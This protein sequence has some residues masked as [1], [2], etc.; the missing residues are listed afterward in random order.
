M[1]ATPHVRH[2]LRV[3]LVPS[4]DI[5]GYLLV[6]HKND[7][8]PCIVFMS[9]SLAAVVEDNFIANGF[10]H[11]AVRVLIGPLEGSVSIRQALMQRFSQPIR[12]D[13]LHLVDSPLRVFLPPSVN[14]NKINREACGIHKQKQPRRRQ[15]NVHP[16]ADKYTKRRKAAKH[17]KRRERHR[18]C[19]RRPSRSTKTAQPGTTC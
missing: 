6:A 7:T 4:P 5:F 16:S 18:A 17:T 15:R 3:V 19:A 2:R 11:T 10:L 9:L 13:T 1:K 8:L 12:C 14:E